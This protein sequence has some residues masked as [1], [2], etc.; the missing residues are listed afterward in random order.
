M[1]ITKREMVH[2]LPAM[3]KQFAPGKKEEFIKEVELNWFRQCDEINV[4]VGTFVVWSVEF[5][6]YL[7]ISSKIKISCPHCGTI[8]EEGDF[9]KKPRIEESTKKVVDQNE[10]GEFCFK[11]IKN[12]QYFFECPMC[13]EEFYVERIEE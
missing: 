9:T 13:G 3:E 10:N 2:F 12:V 11:E 7:A 1:K 8:F 6:K 4:D 5:I